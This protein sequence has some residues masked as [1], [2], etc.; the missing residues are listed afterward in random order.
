MGMFDSYWVSWAGRGREVQTKQFDSFQRGFGFADRVP[1]AEWERDDD[2]AASLSNELQNLLDPF[3]VIAESEYDGGAPE[4]LW[5]LGHW[6]GAL[7][8][9]VHAADEGLLHAGAAGMARV[10]RGPLGAGLR[11]Q[12]DLLTQRDRIARDSLARAREHI[13][14]SFVQRRLD[15]LH[16]RRLREDPQLKTSFLQTLRRYRGPSLK[17]LSRRAVQQALGE[18]G[19]F[20]LGDD[21]MDVMAPLAIRAE[22]PPT[23][24]QAA[25][26]FMGQDSFG[27]RGLGSPCAQDLGRETEPH[28]PPGPTSPEQALQL[29]RD[30]FWFLFEQQAQTHQADQNFLARARDDL[31]E[32]CLSR[33]GAHW[34]SGL[35]H[36]LPWLAPSNI[37]LGPGLDVAMIDWLGIHLGLGDERI[38]PLLAGRSPSRELVL[39]AIEQ[40]RDALAQACADAMGGWAALANG[41]FGAIDQW[42]ASTANPFALEALLQAQAIPE[43]T[44]PMRLALG[45]GEERE[46]RWG[47]PVFDAQGQLSPSLRCLDLMAQRFGP[48]AFDQA[49][50]PRMAEFLAWRDR[51]EMEASA[52]QAPARPAPSL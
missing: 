48:T 25:A 8:D 24:A 4:R 49:R 33:L 40:R 7:V 13:D 19:I 41:A 14:Q 50:S 45:A 52:A 23:A 46:S 6:H 43:L 2:E 29:L 3:F 20:K 16:D 21:P 22:L 28:Q 5:A 1:L 38:V 17:G 9:W 27:G 37:S 35:F 36:R 30:G 34:A 12:L 11:R 26:W 31:N 32:L 18:L 44:P 15:M 47:R 10:W 39:H 51:R 42:A